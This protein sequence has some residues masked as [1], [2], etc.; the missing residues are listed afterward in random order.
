MGGE[1]EKASS[2][3]CGEQKALEDFIDV[4]KQLMGWNEEEGAR[5][6]SVISSD[7]RRGTY[8]ITCEIPSEHNS[9]LLC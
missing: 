7:R 9:F 2:V 4:Y 1:A 5:L 8:Y 6:L 3:Q